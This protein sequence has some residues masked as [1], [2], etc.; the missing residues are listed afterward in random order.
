MRSIG[1]TSKNDRLKFQ[2]E[3]IR[4]YVYYLLE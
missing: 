3:L 1:Q 2:N 4:S